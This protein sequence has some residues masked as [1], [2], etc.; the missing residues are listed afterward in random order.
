MNPLSRVIALFV[1]VSLFGAAPLASIA[2]AEITPQEKKL[3][4]A[5]KKE[6]AVILLNPLFSD[7]T[8]K[9][10]GPAFAK[11]YGL[12]SGFKFNNI[13]K[14]TGDV[15]GQARAEMKAGKFSFDTFVVINPAFFNAAAKKGFFLTLDSGQWKYHVKAVERAGQ[16]HDYPR[17]LVP[18]AYTFQPVWNSSCPGMKDVK[19]NSYWDTVDPKFKGKTIV[20]QIPVSTSYTLTTISMQESGFDLFGFWK[21]LKATA[22]V[23]EARTEPKMQMLITC[24]RSL[25]MWNMAGRVYQNVKKKPALAKILRVGSFKEGQVMLGNQAAVPKGAPHPNA[26]KLLLEFLLSKEGAD[27]FVGGEAVYSFREGYIPPAH[28]RPY[29]LDLSKTKLLGLK[30]WIG[31]AKKVK[32]IRNK[33]TEQFK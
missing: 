17:V 27:I 22:P 32:G 9:Q 7:G 8:A 28:V 13:R 5:A 1:S 16:F 12:G 26:G 24:E 29:L 20:S 14:R 33:W 25:D 10:M 15:V 3:I 11:R 4:R 2:A 30:D 19:I 21:K 23:I 31:A 6:G 18:L